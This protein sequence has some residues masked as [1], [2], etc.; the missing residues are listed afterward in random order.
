MIIYKT[1]NLVNNKIYVGKD[2]NNDP[3][4]LGSGTL[5][6]RAI[7]KYGKDKFKKEILEHCTCLDDLND[8]EIYWINKLDA[9]TNGYNIAV[10]GSGGDTLSNHPRLD[11]IRDKL[12]KTSFWKYDHDGSKRKN[13]SNIFKGDL[14]PMYGKKHTNISKSK[15]GAREYPTGTNHHM[16][17]KHMSSESKNKLSESLKGKPGY[18][19]GKNLPDS[20]RYKMSKIVHQYSIDGEFIKEWNSIADAYRSTGASHISAVCKGKRK[21]SGGYI[22]KYA[23]H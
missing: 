15:I 7:K 1:V 4:Y 17:G 2:Q 11:E 21:N 23:E 10:G 20:T 16:Y 8:R 12:S 6:R 13:H 9:I 19:K 14:N 3:K 5:I 18:W 22:W